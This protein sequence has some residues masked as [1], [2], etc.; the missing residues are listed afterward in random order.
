MIGLEEGTMKKLFCFLVGISFLVSCGGKQPKVDKVIEDGVEVVLNHLEP[1]V[2][3]G[4]PSHLNL[5]EE[6]RLDFEKEEYSGL[7]LKEPD[8]AEAD[9]QGN[10]FVVEQYSASEFFVYKFSPAGEFL[11][12]FGKKGQGPGEIQGIS[13]LIVNKSGHVLISDRSAGK[14]LEFDADGNFVK[15]TKAHYVAQEVVPLENGNY[16]ARRIAK[17]SSES[18]HWFLSLF[19]P[20]FEEIK[21]LD[22]FDMSA[23]VPGKPN[24]G[25][26]IS[27]YW[28]VAGNRIYIGNEQRGYELWVYDL[29]GNMLRKIRKEYKPAPYS[30]E[31]KKQTEELAARQPAMNLVPRQEV[32]P[33][34]S[35]FPDD[36]GR[37]YVMTYEQGQSQDDF[38]HDVF[39][40]DGILIARV[41]LG[42]YGIMGRA[43]NHLRATATNGRFYRVRF[44]ENGYPE[45]I[46]YRM[47]WD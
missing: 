32:P 42:K 28:R 1:Y 9:S 40:K 18:R 37:L 34:N 33:F 31:F 12:K 38:I 13:G 7:G 2:L 10:I 36:E 3:K 11:K 21:K 4:Q 20:D 24:A 25:T 27:F 47:V 17:D 16:L 6:T 41:P 15:E 45:L 22:S 46:V 5:E 44:K 26:I 14:L 23:Y 35:F 43:L 29:E 39:N 8:F 30:E 19:N